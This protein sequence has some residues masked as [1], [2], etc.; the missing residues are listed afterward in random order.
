MK[1]LEYTVPKPYQEFKDVFSKKSFDEL[2]D[3]KKWDHAIEL[4]PD[5]Q[6]FSTK[7]YPLEPVEQKKLDKFLEENL[8]SQCIHLSTFPMA[9]PIFFIKKKDGSLHLIQDN[10]KLNGL[11]M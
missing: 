5:T 6:M 7:V 3:C 4:V 2:L 10:C 9:S 8:K 11:T 1:A